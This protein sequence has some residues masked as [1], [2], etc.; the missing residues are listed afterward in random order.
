MNGKQSG[1]IIALFFSLALPLQANAQAK[2]KS[3]P[4][5]G[6]NK[7]MLAYQGQNYTGAYKLLVPLAKKGYAPAMAQLAYMYEYGIGARK[8]AG[9]AA[10][11]YKKLLSQ[12][13]EQAQQGNAEAQYQVG[14][15]H[16]GGKG[17]PENVPE[18]MRWYAKAGENGHLEAQYKLA[19][20][21]PIVHVEH[22]QMLLLLDED[23]EQEAADAFERAAL[24]KPL[25]A[26]DF[27]DARFAQEQIS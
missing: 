23:N 27:L 14:Q 7:A 4:D 26:M 2:S 3:Q 5:S 15:L 8:D 17:V 20:K 24:L 22:A 16:Y 9:E 10:K 6:F 13:L 18:A 11:L 19:P 21:M 1:A 25:D 12:Y